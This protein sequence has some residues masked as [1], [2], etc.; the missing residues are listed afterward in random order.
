MAAL[1]EVLT[2]LTFLSTAY[3]QMPPEAQVPKD[4]IVDVKQECGKE[5]TQSK[6]CVM[7]D[8]TVFIQLECKGGNLYNFTSVNSVNHCADVY[9]TGDENKRCVYPKR[10]DLRLYCVKVLV[11]VVNKE[12]SSVG[13]NRLLRYTM[14]CTYDENGEQKSGN[15]SIVEQYHA[16][17]GVNGHAGSKTKMG[18]T[19]LL[20]DI[21]G[22]PLTSGVPI[23]KTVCLKV[24][25]D[26]STGLLVGS[27][28]LTLFPVSCEAIGATTGQ[29]HAFIR[30]GC[31]D[32]IIINK[33]TGFSMMPR[34]ALSPYFK[35]F[36][37]END[38]SFSIMCNFTLCSNC[39]GK[40]SCSGAAAKPRS[41]FKLF[42]KWIEAG[43][44][45]RREAP[46]ENAYPGLTLLAEEDFN[47]ADEGRLDSN[48][49]SDRKS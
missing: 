28:P 1:S 18:V 12:G 23:D 20:T 24:V 42:G 7:T 44:R 16:P 14:T 22:V 29:R 13:I 40:N 19:I 10:H 26:N 48:P 47:V 33:T 25:L 21:R 34:A 30:S 49:D 17:K 45:L 11:N 15:S 8:L 38:N 32:G 41:I 36:A 9:F 4:Y 39:V 31:G 5:G 43:N 37:L 35:F 6:V 3:S 27:K 46:A 2:L